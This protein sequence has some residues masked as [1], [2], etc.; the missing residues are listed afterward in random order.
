MPKT[1]KTI[2]RNF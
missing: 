2:L 1:R